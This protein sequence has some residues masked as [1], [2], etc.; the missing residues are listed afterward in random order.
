MD[1]QEFT[2][3]DVQMKTF[4]AWESLR[5]RNGKCSP[6]ERVGVSRKNWPD[7]CELLAAKSRVSLLARPPGAGGSPA[8]VD[9]SWDP[10]HGGVEASEPHLRVTR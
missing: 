7:S 1:Y 2:S 5:F 8:N 3:Q 10:E 9:R 6:R 4:K